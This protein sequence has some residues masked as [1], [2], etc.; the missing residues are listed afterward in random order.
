MILYYTAGILF[1]P[2]GDFS[3]VTDLPKAYK[4]AFDTECENEVDNITLVDFVKIQL[5]NFLMVL[6]LVFR[7]YQNQ[8]HS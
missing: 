4:D 6:M 8:T 3:T 5:I 2:S 1:L 7:Q